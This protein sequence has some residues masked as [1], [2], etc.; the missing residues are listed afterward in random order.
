VYSFI[1]KY[2]LKVFYTLE[3]LADTSNLA[4]DALSDIENGKIACTITT[5]FALAKALKLEPAYLWEVENRQ[6]VVNNCSVLA[7]PLELSLIIRNENNNLFG[8]LQNKWFENSNQ[9]FE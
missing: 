7:T 6:G 2:T 8:I 9:L 1:F 4:Y 3:D 5:V